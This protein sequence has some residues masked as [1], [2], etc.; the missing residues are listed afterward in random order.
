MTALQLLPPT[1]EA[2]G[3][4]ATAE[5]SYA[6]GNKCRLC[7][8]ERARLAREARYAEDRARFGRLKRRSRPASLRKLTLIPPTKKHW[9]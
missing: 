4:P 2:C 9:R 6:R 8:K 3:H 7:N 5:N 1:F